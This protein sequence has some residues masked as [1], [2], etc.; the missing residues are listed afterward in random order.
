[1]I[2]LKIKLSSAL[3]LCV[4]VGCATSSFKI[5]KETN[6][7]TELLVTPDRIILQCEELNEDPD[8]GAY[9][10]MVHVLDE[11]QTVTTSALSIR[12]DKENCER[13]IQKIDRILKNGRQI[14]IWNRT[15]L[16]SQKRR[17]DEPNFR[18]TFPG[19]GIFFSNGRSLEFVT[20]A[21]EKGQC[22]SPTYGKDE[23]C[24]PFPFPIENLK[25]NSTQKENRNGL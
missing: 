14:Y 3:F 17:N 24:P 19:H 16:S 15:K 8:V 5:K 9:G 10:F 6:S 18:Y 21:N 13:F 25:G 1:M 4:F 7:L 20:I 22:Y 11:K 12:P 2:N 23:L